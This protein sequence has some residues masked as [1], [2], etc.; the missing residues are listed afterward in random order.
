M[1]RV[2]P[3]RQG[4][5]SVSLQDFFENAP[6]SGVSAP[7]VVGPRTQGSDEHAW[8]EDVAAFEQPRRL[9]EAATDK[10]MTSSPLMV[11]LASWDDPAL[12][13]R[14]DCDARS[15]AWFVNDFKKKYQAVRVPNKRPWPEFAASV[16]SGFGFTDA[17]A[18][19]LSLASNIDIASLE[20]GRLVVTPNL[21]DRPFQ[22]P[23]LNAGTSCMSTLG[24]MC[25]DARNLLQEN[26][27]R[28]SSKPK[29][30]RDSAISLAIDH[31]QVSSKR[32][33]S[34]VA[35][36]TAALEEYLAQC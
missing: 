4:T 12:R 6:Y 21:L 8:T 7:V 11:A 23:L 15:H 22:T 20:R 30:L 19:A 35:A 29:R 33:E 14:T 34:V 1:R 25:A 32:L 13:F 24:E 2:G 5:G 16:K 31:S 27:V 3:L 9:Q 36:R 28:L 17:D 18:A 26:T 10:N